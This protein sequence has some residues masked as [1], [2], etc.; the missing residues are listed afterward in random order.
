M[1]KNYNSIFEYLNYF[2]KKKKLFLVTLFIFTFFST[3]HYNFIV[4]NNYRIEIIITLDKKKIID[5][6][7][8]ELPDS[9]LNFAYFKY[10]RLF[11]TFI[12]DEVNKNTLLINNY[13][14]N[15]LI[16]LL[17]NLNKSSKNL[18]YEYS[19]G[20]ITTKKYIF[21]INNINNIN[22][23][24]ETIN[25]ENNLLQS[26]ILA[27]IFNSQYFFI[28]ETK[29]NISEDLANLKYV[30]IHKNNTLNELTNK[31]ITDI[32]LRLIEEIFEIKENIKILEVLSNDFVEKI[33]FVNI[34]NNNFI[35]YTLSYTERKLPSLL[36]LLIYILLSFTGSIVI[37]LIRLSYKNHK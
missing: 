13:L 9:E 21:E 19:Y 20:Y 15:F 22:K 5:S 24:E 1:K 32:N 37:I 36:I 23:I 12:E 17:K 14:S 31:N 18:N 6:F 35:D 4:K 8:L 33:R 29:K 25:Y 16:K 28:S 3:L 2:K 27:N 7:K 26:K 10:K 30:L 34:T 11:S